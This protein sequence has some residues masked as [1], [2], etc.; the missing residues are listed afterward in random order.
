MS[1]LSQWAADLKAHFESVEATAKAFLEQ[2]VPGVLAVA[3]K[4]DADPLMQAALSTVLPPEARAMVAQWIADLEEK[5]PRPPA[6]APAP[7]PPAD[8][9]PAG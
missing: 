8:V 6:P 5:F 4:L 7:E 9:P 3:D 1:D 2:H